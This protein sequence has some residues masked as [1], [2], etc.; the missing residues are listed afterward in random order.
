MLHYIVTQG[1]APS[2]QFPELD[3][4][5]NSSA[6]QAALSLLL[7]PPALAIEILALLASKGWLEPLLAWWDEPSLEQVVRSVAKAESRSDGLSLADLI[8]LARAAPV[9][10]GL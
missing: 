7:G 9:S 4:W 1:L 2:W 8:E 5:R 6:A 3:E 10:G